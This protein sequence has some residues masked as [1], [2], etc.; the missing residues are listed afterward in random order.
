M[1]ASSLLGFALGVFGLC[2]RNNLVRLRVA[3]L[4]PVCAHL[5]A[6]T[7]KRRTSRSAFEEIGT[8]RH[9]LARVTRARLP[10]IFKRMLVFYGALA[11]SVIIIAGASVFF[12]Y[13][14]FLV[15]MVEA[16]APRIA[17]PIL[18]L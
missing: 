11:S 5:A 12:V 8:A 14:V 17:V 2:A 1:H 4:R 6:R 3:V 16:L 18:A 10:L 9:A 7:V 13:L 15:K